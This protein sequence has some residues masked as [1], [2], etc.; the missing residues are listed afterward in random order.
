MQWAIQTGKT[1]AWV[2][3][4]LSQPCCV[5]DSFCLPSLSSSP[6]EK[7]RQKASMTVQWLQHY[8][9]SKSCCQTP[10][11]P[12]WQ[13]GECLWC[14]KNKQFQVCSLGLCHL[15]VD[16]SPTTC[17]QWSSPEIRPFPAWYMCSPFLRH[18]PLNIWVHREAYRLCVQKPLP[19]QW[20][21]R[22]V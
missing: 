1:C 11:L 12:W 14:P 13:V 5:T 15:Q 22:I 7:G 16:W 17:K 21:Y 10:L 6:L 9:R 8:L 19:Q 3:A 18:Q 4:W 20:N 2:L